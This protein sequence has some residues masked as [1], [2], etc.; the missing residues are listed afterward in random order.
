MSQPHTWPCATDPI[1]Q[2][3]GPLVRR[4]NGLFLP[5]RFRLPIPILLP[6]ADYGMEDGTWMGHEY[7]QW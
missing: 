1:V 3:L 2:R 4:P 6:Q 5:K 7:I